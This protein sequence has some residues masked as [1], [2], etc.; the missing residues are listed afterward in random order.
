MSRISRIMLAT[1]AAM[2]MGGNDL[3]FKTPHL[4]T[5]EQK[6]N[7]AQKLNKGK[8]FVSEQE[9]VI[10]GHKIMAKSKKDAITKLKHKGLI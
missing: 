4:L 2:M 3:M 1:M 7:R 5:E 10:K 9:F 8:Q 6:R